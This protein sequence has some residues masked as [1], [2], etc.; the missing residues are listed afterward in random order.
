LSDLQI[1]WGPALVLGLAISAYIAHMTRS[2]LLE[3]IRE[4]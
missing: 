4:D 3:I 1:V 2:G